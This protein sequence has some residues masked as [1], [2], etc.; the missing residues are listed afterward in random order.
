ETR[1]HSWNATR[2]RLFDR[3]SG[4]YGSSD[5]PLLAHQQTAVLRQEEIDTAKRVV[6]CKLDHERSSRERGLGVAAVDAVEIAVV[7]AQQ[8]LR[9]AGLSAVEAKD[10][11]ADSVH[12]D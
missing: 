3:V 6:A 7:A 8:E 1:S 12:H 4:R 11:V 10:A 5:A 9:A 2:D